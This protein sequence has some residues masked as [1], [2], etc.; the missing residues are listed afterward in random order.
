MKQRA[1]GGDKFR[2][3]T[4]QTGSDDPPTIERSNFSI[5]TSCGVLLMP[6]LIPCGLMRIRGIGIAT[7]DPSFLFGR[8]SR[9]KIANRSRLI[10]ENAMS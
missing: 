5:H 9:S 10:I 7:H 2:K 8:T 6:I 4:S 3:G 1:L